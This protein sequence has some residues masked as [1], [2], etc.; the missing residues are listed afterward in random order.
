MLGS[1]RLISMPDR[2]TNTI[3]VADRDEPV[4]RPAV[5]NMYDGDLASVT[6]WWKQW[7]QF[8]FES[9]PLVIKTTEGD[10]SQK[11][12]EML[13][14]ISRSKYPAITEVSMK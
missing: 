4:C 10:I 8:M 2:V 9:E 13:K 6:M 14:P 3:N 7:T 11:P 1:K 12:Y 5:I